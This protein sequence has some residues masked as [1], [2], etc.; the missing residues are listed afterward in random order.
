MQSR[1]LMQE[2][3]RHKH[4]KGKNDIWIYLLIYKRLDRIEW[5]VYFFPDFLIPPLTI[6]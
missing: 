5:M 3:L 2:T 4:R 1:L 6:G